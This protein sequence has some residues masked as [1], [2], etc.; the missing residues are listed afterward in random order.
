MEFDGMNDAELTI[1]SLLTETDR[2]GHEVQQIIDERGLREWVHIGYSS[3]FYL[4]DKL[5]NQKMISSTLKPDAHGI[6]RKQYS[7][8][9]AGRGI[10]QTAISDLLRQPRGIGTGFGLG[11]ANVDVL[12]PRQVYQVLSHHHSDLEK[13]LKHVLDLLNSDDASPDPTDS[14]HALYSYSA[15]MMR[16]ELDWLGTFLD[17]WSKKYPE[18]LKPATEP[19]RPDI[20]PEDRVDPHEKPT[21]RMRRPTP[22]PNKQ[23][24]Q[25]KRPKSK[26]SKP[27]EE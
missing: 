6:G 9:N 7:L 25:M 15:S 17:D 24:Q 21:K 14:N 19:E 18:S 12:K 11:V 27:K 2:F 20:L 8:T 1:L 3:L 13:R 23:V 4:L 10:L 22:A 26:P 16:A 5:E